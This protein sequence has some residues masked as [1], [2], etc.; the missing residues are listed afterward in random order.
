[1][2]AFC[3]LP[4]LSALSMTA[5]GQEAKDTVALNEVVV[6]GARVVRRVDGKTVYLTETEKQ[7]AYSS[8]SLL[9]KLAFPDIRIDELSRTVQTISNRGEVQIRINGIIA[10]TNDLQAIDV[11]SI[12]SVDYID[13]PGV[14]YGN[15][16]AYVIDIH[17]RRPTWGYSVGAQAMNTLTALS[18]FN[19]AYASIN[20][21]KSQ[22][23]V[24]YEQGYEDTKG[25]LTS[26]TADYLLSDGTHHLISRNMQD[27]RTRTYDNT[28]ELRYNLA[29][30]ANY[31]FQAT[32]STALSNSP[33]TFS[34]CLVTESGTSDYTT[35][36][37][38]KERS[39]NPVIDLYYQQQLGNHQILTANAVGTYIHTISNNFNDEGGAYDYDVNGDTYS[40]IGEA[41]YENKLKPFT[42][43]AGLNT[44]WKYISNNYSGDVASSNNIHRIDTYAF[45]QIK[46]ALGKL[47]YMT[48]I[49]ASYD[50]YRQGEN[51]YSYWLWRPKMQLSYPI[52]TGVNLSYSIELSQHI[53]NIAMISDTRIRQNSMEWKV[54]N[55]VLKPN[56]Q[57]EN[58]LSFSYNRT[59]FYTQLTA[60]YRVN[61]NC[62][63][64]KYIRTT[65]NQF[66][67]L[68][69]NQ[70]H[71]NMIYLNSYNNVDIIANRLSLG[72]N[73]SMARF[74]N[75]GDNYDQCYTSFSASGNVT[76]YFGKWTVQLS[77]DSGWR[78]MEAEM[79]GYNAGTLMAAAS[80]R[81]GNCDITVFCINPFQHN[82][83]KYRSTIV[84]QF[85]N[86]CTSLHST[87][88]G[89]AVQLS[90]AWRLTGGKKHTE[91][92][93]K[94]KNKDKVTGI[95]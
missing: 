51:E 62:N 18:G 1:M 58:T 92:E 20:N 81:I 67:Y 80:Y 71:Y 15:G 70:P 78:F 42:L 49:G 53:S 47:M 50:H 56:S 48:G 41:I 73:G 25:S 33:R 61:R 77:A 72:L 23:R 27:S 43:T 26:E 17:T 69:V 86:K 79:K 8:Y 52:L 21:K 12:T 63:L 30:S 83:L 88:A 9:K 65:D 45:A 64:G 40:L 7:H 85:V 89:N 3:M 16:I 54:G 55:P 94:L 6:K 84:N 5:Y 11:A 13:N 93:Q 95:M 74:F 19:N 68:Q 39:A 4:L 59:G 34:H 29:D 44:S 31:V 24:F 2:I 87:D 28:L 91:V 10:N 36:E 35:T 32:F 22:L 90:V 38:N 14:R 57:L 46:G 75:R 60:M 82:P 76:G 37:S 66:L